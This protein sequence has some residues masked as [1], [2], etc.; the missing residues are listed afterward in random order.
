MYGRE[1][2]IKKTFFD[3][4]I[5]LLMKRTDSSFGSLLV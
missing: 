4:V 2:C 5:T 1:F 3:F